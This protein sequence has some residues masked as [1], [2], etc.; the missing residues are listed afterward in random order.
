M[1][2]VKRIKNAPSDFKKVAPTLFEFERRLDE[3]QK[4]KVSKLSSKS[5]EKIWKIIQVHHERSLYVYR[6]YYKRKIISRELYDFLIKNKFADK[7]LIAKWR[8]QGYEKLCCLRCI[9]KDESTHGTTCICRVPR[10]QL[11]AEAEKK[12]TQVTFKQCVHCG[13]R[14]CASTD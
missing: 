1:S 9:Q 4:E 12:G 5:Q 6:L 7:H 8:K 3:V 2:T 11:E 14:G 10:A 13:C